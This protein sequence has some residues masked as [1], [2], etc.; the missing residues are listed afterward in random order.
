MRLKKFAAPRL[1]EV[2]SLMTLT[3]MSATISGAGAGD[4]GDTFN[5]V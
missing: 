4:G 5:P 2:A 1:V 3:Q